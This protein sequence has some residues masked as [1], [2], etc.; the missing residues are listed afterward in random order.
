MGKGFDLMEGRGT[1]KFGGV[2][3]FLGVGCHFRGGGS[4]GLG[5]VG[6]GCGFLGGP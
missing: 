6:F 5:G 2:E 1:W 3:K 4:L